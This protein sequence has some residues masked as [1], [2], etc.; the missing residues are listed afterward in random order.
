MHRPFYPTILIAGLYG[1]FVFL[2]NKSKVLK[3]KQ[4]AKDIAGWVAAILVMTTLGLIFGLT[5]VDLL[6]VGSDNENWGTPIY[7]VFM[8]MIPL[9]F[10]TPLYLYDR[11]CRY[12]LPNGGTWFCEEL[13]ARLC[14]DEYGHSFFV[15]NQKNIPCR[16]EVGSKNGYIYL[17]SD[18]LLKECLFS[19]KFVSR[20]KKKMKIQDRERQCIYTFV[21]YNTYN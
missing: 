18:D 9:I 2:I 6:A 10:I 7:D 21:P 8:V 20:T 12:E 1:V 4:K 15:K 13:Q 5:N 11:I 17:F 14:F 3:N 19:G 16:L